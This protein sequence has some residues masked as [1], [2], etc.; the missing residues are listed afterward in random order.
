M[1]T[2]LTESPSTIQNRLPEELAELEAEISGFSP[3]ELRTL[4]VL[5]S[6]VRGTMDPLKVSLLFE[7]MLEDLGFR[8]E[9]QVHSDESGEQP[10]SENEP[11]PGVLRFH[12]LPH[13]EIAGEDFCGWIDL[14][15]HDPSREISTRERR[16][17]EYFCRQV[18]LVL[19]HQWLYQNLSWAQDSLRSALNTLQEVAAF[20]GHEIRSPIASL[21]SLAFLM[22]DQVREMTHKPALSRDDW[23]TLLDK[24]AQATTLVEKV[25]R[26]TYLLGTL[27]I[28]PKAMS[29]DLEWVEIGKSLLVTAATAYSFEIKRRNLLVVIRRESGFANDYVQVHRAWFEAIFD[30]L[31]GNAVKYSSEGGRVD[32]SIL[33]QNGDYVIHVSNPVLFPPSPERLNRLFEKGYRGT[34]RGF[35]IQSIGA[36][37]GLGLYFVNRIVTLG[38]G[39]KVRVWLDPDRNRDGSK[40]KDRMETQ[41]FGDP[42]TPKSPPTNEYFHIEIRLPGRALQGLGDEE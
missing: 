28:D 37:Q 11:P 18:G 30:N 17:L 25:T 8:S 21:C 22:E 9:I 27:E 34:E 26:S 39:G 1:D 33:K 4:V 38:Y 14:V 19:A 35:S 13:P 6:M 16:Y 41:V 7:T 5:N 12:F 10:Q 42:D 24:M 40:D 2:E 20:I 29:Q 36:N 15:P 23:R 3:D 31:L 32:F